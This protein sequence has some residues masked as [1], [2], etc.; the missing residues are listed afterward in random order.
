LVKKA[1]VDPDFKALVLAKRAEAAREI[2]LTLDA[3]EV[4]ILNS[5]PAKQLEAII[6]RTHVDVESRA[7][8]LGRAAALMLAA[9]GVEAM[10]SEE[11][12]D[13]PKTRPTAPE[14]KAS[15]GVESGMSAKAQNSSVKGK[16]A[17]P[18]NAQDEK[19]TAGTVAQKKLK[20][21]PGDAKTSSGR[22]TRFQ[23]RGIA[24]TPTPPPVT[25]VPRWRRYK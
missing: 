8:F 16:T 18:P 19:T 4:E 10:T 17:A 6:A 5:V 15:D 3:A 7:A 13:A 9:L 2:D 14:G 11:T 25:G 1:S 12:K 20:T 21:Q 23:T 22:P 24:P